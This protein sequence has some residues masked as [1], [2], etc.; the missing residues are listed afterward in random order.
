MAVR[1]FICGISGTGIDQEEAAF[2]R[3]ADPFGL[4]L[5]RRNVDNPAQVQALTAKVREI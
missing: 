2:L 5:F 1:A 4:I 3:T